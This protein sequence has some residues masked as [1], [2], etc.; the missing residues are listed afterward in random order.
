LKNTHPNL[1]KPILLGSVRYKLP[2]KNSNPHS[3]C[4]VFWSF[5]LNKKTTQTL[6]IKGKI[7]MLL[8][9]G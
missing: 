6:I 8:D 2:S 9:Q 5:D 4:N 3:S 7:E 1:A